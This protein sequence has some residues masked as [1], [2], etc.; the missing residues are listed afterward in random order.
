MKSI[1]SKKLQYFQ[2]V[3]FMTTSSAELTDKLFNL[4][5]VKEKCE[6]IQ[7]TGRSQEEET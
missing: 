2:T 1:V 4:S 7:I 3:T 5:D 6:E